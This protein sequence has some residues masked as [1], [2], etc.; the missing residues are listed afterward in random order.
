MLVFHPDVHKGRAINDG[1]G[2]ETLEHKSEADVMVMW[3]RMAKTMIA[4]MG[5]IVCGAGASL[6]DD[7]TAVRFGEYEGHTRIVVETD[8]P[9]TFRAFTLSDPAARLVIQFDAVGWGVT[10]LPGGAGRGVGP[11]G[12]FSFEENARAPRLVFALSEPS[13]V[14]ESFSL[15]PASGGYRTVID[16]EPVSEAAFVRTAGFPEQTRT[17]EDILL[18]EVG[19]VPQCDRVRVVLDPGHGGRD[20]GATARWGGGHEKDVNLAAALV[21][22]DLLVATG[23]YDVVMTRDTD[24]FVELEDRV[25][26]A[27]EARADLFISLHADSAG[28]NHA[29]QGATVYSMNHRA[30][31]RARSRAIRG[32]DWVDPHRPEEVTRILVEMALANKEGES[33]VFA[34]ALRQEVGRTTVMWRDQPMQA[35]F[36]VLTEAS[37]PAVLFEMGFLTNREDARRLNDPEEQRSMMQGAV[38]AI[39]SR[40]T[41]CG[42]NVASGYLA[43]AGSASST[44]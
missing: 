36:A 10:D 40:F 31:T 11:V 16:I 30:V 5:V 13:L 25:R 8:Q 32:G 3:V 26:I 24:V 28:D 37:T 41:R 6:A 4:A 7:I 33:E 12:I 23:R 17:L 22:R 44:R 14:R 9:V 35:N 42:G 18:E 43:Q 15:D 34:E 21:L 38:A 20:P 1:A 2:R 29:P 27:R 39:E 19:A